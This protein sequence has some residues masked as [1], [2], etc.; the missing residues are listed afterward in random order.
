[1]KSKK[2]SQFDFLALRKRYRLTQAELADMVMVSK[3]YIC[4]IE[5]GRKVPSPSLIQLAR[6][7]ERELAINPPLKNQDLAYN[8]PENGSNPAF[9]Y[10]R[11]VWEMTE[12][13]RHLQGYIVTQL[14][15]TFPLDKPPF[16]TSG[17]GS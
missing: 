6:R 17:N 11:K 5:T 3:N 15:L 13:D 7:I 4:Q 10:L 1:M 8:D 12:G 9:D 14:K 16:S 2:Q